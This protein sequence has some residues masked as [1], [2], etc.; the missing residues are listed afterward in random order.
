MSVRQRLAAG[1]RRC[2]RASPA[3]RPQQA[4]RDRNRQAAGGGSPD[5][6][7]LPRLAA[8]GGGAGRGGREP[9]FEAAGRAVDDEQRGVGLGRPRNHVG[10][11]VAVSGRVQQRHVAA[12]RLNAAPA[13]AAAGEAVVVGGHGAARA[14]RKAQ[15]CARPG[16]DQ[17]CSL[18]RYNACQVAAATHRVTATSTVTPRARS[19]G[20]SSSIQAQAKE[21]LPM[22]AASRCGNSS[23][24]VQQRGGASAAGCPGAPAPVLAGLRA[25]A[26]AGRGPH[27][28]KHLPHTRRP[29]T[30]VLCTAVSETRPSS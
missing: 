1:L 8:A 28:S 16:L 19:S 26:A 6:R 14:L 12:R 23:G 25:P 2:S 20:R 24:Q 22:A 21:P 30:C 3:C 18:C 4:P 15:R 5:L 27:T 17:A 29:P 13:A 9:G 7:V 11:K 10:H